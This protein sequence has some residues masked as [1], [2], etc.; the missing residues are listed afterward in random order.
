M[1]KEYRNKPKKIS[2]V[3]FTNDNKDQVYNSLTGQFCAGFEDGNPILKITTIHRDI[4]TVR[5]G[6]WIVKENELGYY[7]PIRDDVFRRD[8]M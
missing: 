2:A 8:Y 1:F 6:D 4:V 7:Y 3:Q 5:L